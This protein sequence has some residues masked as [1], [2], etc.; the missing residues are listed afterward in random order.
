M[1][2]NS[3]KDKDKYDFISYPN[4]SKIYDKT[5]KMEISKIKDE[6]EGVPMVEYAGLICKMYSVKKGNGAEDKKAKGI[7][8]KRH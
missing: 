5:S 6:A 3:H 4:S 1:Y 2:D 7:L 8:K